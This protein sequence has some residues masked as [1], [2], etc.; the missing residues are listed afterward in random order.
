MNQLYGREGS[1][2][3]EHVGGEGA[4]DAMADKK[5]SHARGGRRVMYFNVLVQVLGKVKSFAKHQ[6]TAP[7][8][9]EA[10]DDAAA[11]LLD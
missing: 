11:S 6:L 4:V 9:E 3:E 1:A 10:E 5:V 7:E 8:P 2:S